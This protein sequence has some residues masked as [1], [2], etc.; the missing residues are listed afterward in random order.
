MVLLAA[1]ADRVS[2]GLPCGSIR[3]AGLRCLRKAPGALDPAFTSDELPF[4][5]LRPVQHFNWLWKCRL[6]VVQ[7]QAAYTT[8][9]AVADVV[10]VM[11]ALGHDRMTLVAH[12][13][14]GM[15]G[16]CAADVLLQH[17]TQMLICVTVCGRA[18]VVANCDACASLVHPVPLLSCGALHWLIDDHTKSFF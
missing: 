2:A 17:Q 10:G 8:E 5:L 12:D 11:E 3:H 6:P 14:G 9:N 7:D 4:W 15:V 16:W 18:M 1:P 13:W